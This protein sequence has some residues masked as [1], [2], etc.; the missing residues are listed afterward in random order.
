MG[1]RG[2]LVQIQSSRPFLLDTSS[3]LK[4][5]PELWAKKSNIAFLYLGIAS[6]LR[7]YITE[8]LSPFTK[9][10]PQLRGNCLEARGRYGRGVLPLLIRERGSVGKLMLTYFLDQKDST[11]PNFQA[12][13]SL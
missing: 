1:F 13:P 9:W 11:S 8:F 10:P 7:L 2:S 5:L 3:G 6:S 4:G 12:F